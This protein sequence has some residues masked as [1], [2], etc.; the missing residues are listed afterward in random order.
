M[1][2]PKKRESSGMLCSGETI[3]ASYF[4]ENLAF[5]TLRPNLV[6]NICAS[7]RPRKPFDQIFD[8]P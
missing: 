6:E 4:A 5:A 8:L 7:R 1:M 3:L 2:I